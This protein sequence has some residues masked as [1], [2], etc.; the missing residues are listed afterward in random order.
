MILAPTCCQFCGL[1]V[2][3]RFL[4]PRQKQHHDSV[5]CSAPAER[6]HHPEGSDH[7]LKRPKT[8]ALAWRINASRSRVLQIS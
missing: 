1:L 3:V 7:I 4:S 6:P 5:W 2:I 8:I